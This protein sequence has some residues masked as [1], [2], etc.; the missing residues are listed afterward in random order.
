MRLP[1]FI[2]F[3]GADAN[4]CRERMRLLS[5]LYPIEWG[6]L[7]SPS[8]QGIDP[9]FPAGEALRELRRMANTVRMSAHLCGGYARAAMD[10]EPVETPIDLWAFDRV[11]VN[12]TAPNAASLVRFQKRA[13]V[14]GIIAQCR[15]RTFP[16]GT[17]VHW[18]FDCSGG[19][20]ERAKFWPPH[21]GDGITVGY[22]GGITPDNVLDVL[23]EIASAGPYWVDM[24][25]GVR[26]AE[27]FDLDKVEAVCRAVYG[28][29]G[30]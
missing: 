11:Q 6:V 26:T 12:H 19:R 30:R 7:L 27:A 10:G 2:T 5:S 20:G 18:L 8:K 15:G 16:A 24:E 21:P 23:E 14:G 29:R 1:D 3:T 28:E 13:E 22:A 17:R 9:R 4:T 25:T